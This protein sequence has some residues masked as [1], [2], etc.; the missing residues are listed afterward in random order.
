M[1]QNQTEEVKRIKVRLKTGPHNDAGTTDRLYLGVVGLGG[2]R[3]FPLDAPKFADHQESNKEATY[4]I[5][6]VHDEVAPSGT[7]LLVKV[8]NNRTGVW[9]ID[10][11]TV[12]QV[13]LRKWGHTKY[14]VDDAYQLK[15]VE[16]TLFGRKPNT[17]TFKQT[18]TIWLGAEYGLQVWI[19]EKL[20]K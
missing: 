4:W 7:K 9:R 12:N 18:E 15:E 13:Y 17:R 3:E 2:G 14:K 8:R 5:G 19:P 20:E 11:D 6:E 1:P 10:F 16:V